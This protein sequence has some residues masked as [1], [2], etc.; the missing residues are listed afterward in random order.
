MAD[1]LQVIK[2]RDFG[3]ATVMLR[4][5]VDPAVIG[6][7][8]GVDMPAGP[9]CASASGTTV[10][11]I[12]PGV[13]LAFTPKAEPT[14]VSDL[15]TSITGA[16][17]SDQS[18]GYVILQLSGQ[19]ARSVLQKGAFID[20]DPLKFGAGSAATTVIGHI[21]VVIWQAEASTTFHIALFRSFAESFHG[22]LGS[23]A[24]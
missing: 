11:G 20:L 18:G 3:L 16:S 22:W 12:G 17:V 2:C 1:D 5:N 7:A 4:K 14:W 8:F 24:L 21:G 23:A 19:A 15:A 13:W 6:A 9:T 10:I